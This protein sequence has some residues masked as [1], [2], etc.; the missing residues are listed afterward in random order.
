[1]S[2]KFPG[3]YPTLIA[4]VS[5]FAI[6]FTALQAAH[7]QD[8]EIN[9]AQLIIVD[10][11]ALQDAALVSA[12]PSK[13]AKQINN[14][15]RVAIFMLQK[16][17]GYLHQGK[18]KQAIKHFKNSK[19]FTNLY[20]KLLS[21]KVERNK[22]SPV[23]AEPLQLSA[24]TIR[25]HINQLIL[26]DLGNSQPVADAGI[27]Q[28]AEIGQLITL[29]GSASTDPDGDT[30]LYQWLIIVQPTGSTAVLNDAQSATASFTAMVAGS[31]IVE[32]V[33]SDGQI[34]S[35]PDSV[36]VNVSSGNTQPVANAGA[37]QTGLVG[38]SITLDG[39]DSSDADGDSLSYLW[40]L[41][42]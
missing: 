8:P 39:S 34:S 41:V 36:T 38:E 18:D 21:Q 24:I 23:V 32:L 12:M 28:S 7:T 42:T 14:R 29:D 10:I 16:G 35:I 6:A 9:F 2:K 27:D 4:L 15:L 33:V 40:T 17:I 25:S 22:I 5:A 19:H 13:Q 1:M 11:E 26:G 3:Y 30:L 31:Y 20:L 37:D